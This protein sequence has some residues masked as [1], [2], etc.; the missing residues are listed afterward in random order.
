MDNINLMEYWQNS[1]D[2]VYFE[3]TYRKHDNF[4]K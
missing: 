3:F 1:S 4:K 2:E